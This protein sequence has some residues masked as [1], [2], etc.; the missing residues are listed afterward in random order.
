MDDDERSEDGADEER[1]SSA[2]DLLRKG[3]PPPP[4]FE[5][6]RPTL[7]PKPLQERDVSSETGTTDGANAGRA[8]AAGTVVMTSPMAGALIG[9]FIDAHFVKHGS[10]LWTVILALAGTVSGFM[11][12]LR[13]LSMGKRENK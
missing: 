10:Y 11:S 13:I 3:L 8:L 4:N 6:F 1:S 12:M 7:G 9:L 2:S 5:Y